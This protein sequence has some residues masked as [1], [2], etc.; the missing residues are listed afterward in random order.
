MNDTIYGIDFGTTNS[1]LALME[2]AG[3]RVIEIDDQPT[4]PSVVSFD[5]GSGEVIVGERARNRLMLDPESTVRSIKRQ[6]GDEETLAVGGRDRRPEEIAAEILR[7]LKQRGEEALG[8]PIERAVITVPAYYED[9][10]RRATIR[11]GELAGLEVVRIIN[12]PTAAALVYDRLRLRGAG[13][14]IAG[15]TATAGSETAERILV[16]DLG[17]GTFD[18]SV[19]EIAGELNEVRASCGDNHL[20]GDDFDQ[21]LA[22]YLLELAGGSAPVPPR[23]QARL[24][25]AAER[26]KIDLSR[27]PYV[28]VIEEALVD[29]RH[30]D[31]ELA[32]RTFEELIEQRLSVAQREVD[33]ALDEA[34]LRPDQ[35]DRVVLVGGSTH[36]PRLRELLDERFACPVEHA[37][38]PAL[39]VALGAAVQGALLGGQIFDH[40]LVDVAAHSLGIKVLG[41]EDHPH[42][43]MITGADTFSALIRRN[44]QIPATWSEVYRTL[45]DEQP[46][47]DVEVYQGESR[48]CSENTLIG[49]F[50]FELRPAPA[51]GE[52]VVEFSYDLDGVVRVVVEQRGFDNRKEVTVD[53]RERKVDALPDKLGP[54]VDNYMIRKARSLAG[55]LGAL[56]ESDA[57]ELR[58]RLEGAAGA[59]EK[60]LASGDDEVVD[61][62]EDQLLEVLDEAEEALDGAEATAEEPPNGDD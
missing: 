20:G 15:R 1:C 34:R 22:D 48:L 23:V 33:R 29:G 50:E 53:T 24:R 62:F 12:E 47:V 46:W 56:P 43:W 27:Q 37:V 7:Y 4:V 60:A 25:D 45:H 30:L 51:G 14:E 16:Y 36:I 54:A 38:D 2:P 5:A 28:R 55:R 32:R 35:I 10:Q 42:Q 31:A 52:V 19:V 39:C 40:I 61:R 59:Y 18:V 57:G 8:R 17:G 41:E 26:A 44:T 21:L 9:A 58:Q 49:Q 11:A 13:G 3:P 6:M